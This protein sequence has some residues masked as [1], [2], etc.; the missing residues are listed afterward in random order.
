MKEG[1]PLAVKQ[2]KPFDFKDE[3][4]EVLTRQLGYKQNEAQDMIYTALIKNKNIKNIEELLKE[5]YS[6]KL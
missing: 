3:A 2:E 1:E 6:L 5:I 4:L